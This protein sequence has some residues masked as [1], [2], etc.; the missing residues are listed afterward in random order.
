MRELGDKNQRSGP[1]KPG[2]ALFSTKIY[3]SSTFLNF[4]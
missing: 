4:N 2:N 3:F 1:G